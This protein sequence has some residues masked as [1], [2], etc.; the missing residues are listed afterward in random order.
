MIEQWSLHKS[1]F[2]ALLFI[3][4]V[5]QLIDS[6]NFAYNIKHSWMLQVYIGVHNALATNVSKIHAET[7]TKKIKILPYES[8][9]A[10]DDI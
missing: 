3:F 2:H 5:D 9:E 6:Q 4:H 1:F 8:S 7:T 10:S